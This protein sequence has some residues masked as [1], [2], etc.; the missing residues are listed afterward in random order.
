MCTRILHTV[1]QVKKTYDTENGSI[2]SSLR[3][4]DTRR[5]G[6]PCM[7]VWLHTN[8][9]VSVSFTMAVTIPPK[10]CE[11]TGKDIACPLCG[12]ELSRWSSVARHMKTQ[13]KDSE[14]TD[15]YRKAYHEVT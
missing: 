4:T 7:C 3:S 11:V 14:D 12:K 15:V 2:D 5:F 9:V 6:Y 1:I 8:R 13:H 10:K